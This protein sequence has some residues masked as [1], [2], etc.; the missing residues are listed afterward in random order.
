MKIL[1][2]SHLIP[3]PPKGGALQRSYY[4]L[5]EVARYHDVDLLAFN[6]QKLISPL[7]ESYANGIKEAYEALSVFCRRLAF[8]DIP[9]D[10]HSFGL[11]VLALKSL[12]YEPFTINWLK[13][14]EFTSEMS[15]WLL[16]GD[17]DIVH[18]DTISLVPFF[19]LVPSS[20]PTSLDHHNIE[21]HM[22]LRRANKEKN[23]VKKFYF[24]QEGVRLKRYER[25]FCPQFSINLTCSDMDTKRLIEITPDSKVFIIPNGVD[26]DY[27]KPQ[28]L[29]IKNNQLLFV[30]GMNW[31]PNIEAVLYIAE[32]I[33]LPLKKMRQD[34]QFHVVGANPPESICALKDRLPDFHVHGFVDDV[35]P[36]IE[37]ATV[38]LCPIQ[39]G[40]GTKLKI[41]DAMAMKKAIVAHPIACEGINVKHGYNVL[42]ADTPE[43]FIENIV[44]LLLNPE[45]RTVIGAAARKL[46][47][48]EYDYQIIGRKLSDVFLGATTYSTD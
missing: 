40:G 29:P 1:W 42:L 48:N 9:S 11:H 47:E 21:S 34:L 41:L 46:M 39:D 7:F 2:L 30:G 4:L 38:Y 12:L 8:F 18:F 17:Y 24:W 32:K 19:S 6:Q 14:R 15:E 22:L 28:D 31:Y 20:M 33:W 25:Y 3:Y 36:L 16:Q 35:R 10:R 23:I 26:I 27:F 44:H 37:S 13:S 5:K 45:K 43:L